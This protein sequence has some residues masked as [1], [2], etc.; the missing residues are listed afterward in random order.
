MNDIESDEKS[1]IPTSMEQL[2]LFQF[3]ILE[4]QTSISHLVRSNQEM[5]EYHDLSED[6]DADLLVFIRENLAV[7][8]KQTRTIFKLIEQ[9][10]KIDVGIARSLS[11]KYREQLS[12]QQGTAIADAHDDEED[13]VSL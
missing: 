2:E 10:E 9:I 3:R 11:Q 7:I 4:L 12:K 1:T 5:K 8:E 6:K 13:G